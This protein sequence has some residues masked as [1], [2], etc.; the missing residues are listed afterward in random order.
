MKKKGLFAGMALVLTFALV[1]TGCPPEP[2]TI[3]KPSYVTVTKNSGGGEVTLD[4]AAVGGA[5]K[6]SI[7]YTESGSSTIYF[8][9]YY[10]STGGTVR[11]LSYG[12]TYTFYV[13]AWDSRDNKS[14]AA[15][16][17]VLV[18][19]NA[20]AGTLAAPTGL[21][22]TSNVNGR[23]SL[24][25]NAVSGAEGYIVDYTGGG[26]SSWRG[27]HIAATNR[28]DISGFTAGAVYDFRVQAYR[29]FPA[30]LIFGS[31]SYLQSITAKGP[32]R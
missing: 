29:E 23:I 4:W 17:T 26:L 5:Y 11:L 3:E 19:S 31:Y 15:T 24:S 13:Y 30:P 8:D 32:G 2:E 27:G 25:W 18:A 9:G 16:T 28:I 20:G 14:E 1:L 7:D 21:E 6:Y 10:Y 22:V 12:R